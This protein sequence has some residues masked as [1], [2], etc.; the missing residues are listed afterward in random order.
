[1]STT[2]NITIST[3]LDKRTSSEL[4]QYLQ[5]YRAKYGEMVRYTWYHYARI[6]PRPKK[7]DFNT[8]LQKKYGVVKRIAN[9]VITDTVGRYNALVELKKK[10]CEELEEKVDSLNHSIDELAKEVKKGAKLAANNKLT[11]EEL[12]IYRGK[13]RSLFFKR[14]KLNTLQNRLLQRRRDIKAGRYKICFGTKKIFKAQN[15]LLENGYKSKISWKKDFVSHRDSTILYLGSKGEKGN[16]QNFQLTPQKDGTF[17]IQCRKLGKLGKKE[18]YVVGNCKF[19]YLGTKLR[20]LLRNKHGIT[21]RVCFKGKK[22]YLQAIIILDNSF[23][24]TNMC[25]GAIGLDYNDGFIQMAETNKSGNLVNQKKYKLVLHGTG[26][27]AENEIRQTIAGISK[28]ALMAGKS[29]VCENLDF[30]KKKSRMLKAKGKKGKKYNQMLHKFD[31]SRYKETLEN[32]A[33]RNQIDLIF[34][35]PAYTSKIAEKKYCRKRKLNIHTGA[36][37]V[38]ARRGQGFK[39]RLPKRK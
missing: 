17:L 29:I 28:Y 11:E 31:Y 3:R 15:H 38:I 34:V 10:E 35:N 26:T 27:R 6:K 1:M 13:K 36:A 33:I 22:V 8:E 16:N 2:H 19:P 7:S 37:Y 4:I 30:S 32:S 23:I 21:Y 12:V 5:E 9:S 24:V 20:E 14:Q 18:K 39:D 25:D